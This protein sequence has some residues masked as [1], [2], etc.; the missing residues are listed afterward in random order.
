MVAGMGQALLITLREG[1]EIGLVVAILLGYVHKTGRPELFRSVLVGSASAA[2]LS[3]ISA[4]VFY[5]VVGD[6]VGKTEQIVE[7]LLAITAC[8]TL[9]W[10]I[11]WMRAHAREMS[12]SLQAKVEA[13]SK[14]QKAVAV[15]AF[16]AV[17]REGFEAALLLV[18]GRVNEAKGLSVVLGGLVGLAIASVLSARAHGATS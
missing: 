18:A 2:A 6:F 11:F 12:G 10:M 7:F 8:V 13:A 9:T 4:V 16:A 17:A 1:L 3:L 15:V 14:S 5:N